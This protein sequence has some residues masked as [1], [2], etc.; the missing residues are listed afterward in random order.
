VRSRTEPL[1]ATH[2]T[3]IEHL[4]TARSSH[5]GAEAMTALAHQL[6]R[7]IGPLHGFPLSRERE[8][9][10]ATPRRDSHTTTRLARNNHP[11]EALPPSRDGCRSIARLIREGLSSVNA[12][13]M[14]GIDPRTHPVPT[15]HAKQMDP[16]VKPA[17]ERRQSASAR[18]SSRFREPVRKA[19][20]NHGENPVAI[21]MLVYI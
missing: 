11:R 18:H 4:A 14:C 9:F 21:A 19:T 3:R 6:A 8:L 16:R 10:R 17:G 15:I 1:A 13:G 2:A 5:P 20:S 12:Q 7:L